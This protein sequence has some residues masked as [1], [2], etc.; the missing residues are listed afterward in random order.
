MLKANK[1]TLDMNR[2]AALFLRD[3]QNVSS[4]RS[5]KKMKIINKSGKNLSYSGYGFTT[6]NVLPRTTNIFSAT[7]GTLTPSMGR[8]FGTAYTAMLSTITSP[9]YRTDL[10]L[11]VQGFD[12]KN[13][14]LM[15]APLRCANDAMMAFYGKDLSF[16]I[17]LP[18]MMLFDD[19][20]RQA[21][22][23]GYAD[24][25]RQY[26]GVDSL[27]QL[28]IDTIY[29]ILGTTRSAQSAVTNWRDNSIDGKPIP[30]AEVGQLTNSFKI[31]G[32]ADLNADPEDSAAY[33]YVP[34]FHMMETDPEV[35]QLAYDYLYT[36]GLRFTLD[37]QKAPYSKLDSE[38]GMGGN[39][40]IKAYI[41][42]TAGANAHVQ[43]IFGRSVLKNGATI[44]L[45]HVSAGL[46]VPNAWNQYRLYDF[47][48]S[49]NYSVVA[50]PIIDIP[51]TGENGFWLTV[52]GG[53]LLVAAILL[54]IYR[55]LKR[56][57]S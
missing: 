2:F 47:G 11:P 23:A 14:N 56:K 20:L 9:T 28:P 4:N 30:A 34:N 21:G 33:P 6:E 7:N 53:V 51:R 44:T 29:N 10:C 15:I 36:N 38:W 12:D 35:I 18:Q 49:L 22:Y 19:N 41:D 54:L 43:S 13:I 16:E 24:Y 48:F 42:R 1:L 37:D 32:I 25:L 50:A 40:G 27:Y 26:Y 46:Y 17:N 3:F 5:T 57:N 45:D 52:L 55:Y 31:W 39:F 8:A